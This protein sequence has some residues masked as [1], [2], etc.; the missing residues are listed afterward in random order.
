[1]TKS[2]SSVYA[3]HFV[4]SWAAGDAV[5]LH[6]G[7]CLASD[8]YATYSAWASWNGELV[9]EEARFI[10]I[11]KGKEQK[12][13]SAKLEW[14]LDQSGE[15]QTEAVVIRPVNGCRFPRGAKESMAAYT[16]RSVHVFS[17]AAASGKFSL[18]FPIFEDGDLE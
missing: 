8:L 17:A 10:A 16:G 7:P 12:A 6:V 13:V 2:A 15:R 3:Y 1:M 9:I 18:D 11:C 4:E 14:V 5:G